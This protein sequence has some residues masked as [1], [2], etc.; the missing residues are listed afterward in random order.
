MSRAI[1]DQVCTALKSRQTWEERQIVWRQMRRDGLRRRRKPY[2]GAA[3]LHFPLISMQ[4]EKL[5][6]FYYGQ[7]FAND[8]L[9]RFGGLIPQ[10]RAAESAAAEFFDWQIKN[11]S[12]FNLEL[13]FLIDAMLISGRGVLKVRWGMDRIVFECVDPLF[14][15]VPDY[16]TDLEEAPWVCQV[17][18]MSK[19]QYEAEPLYEQNPDLIKAIAGKDDTAQGD[20]EQYQ[21]AGITEADDAGQIILWEVWTRCE[22]KWLVSTFSPKAPDKPVR[23][24]FYAARLQFVDFPFELCERG[25]YG[26]MGVAEHQAPFEAWCCK[27]WN[28][29]A[30]A[31]DFFNKPL[32][33]TTGQIRNTQNL[34]FAPGEMLPDG[35]EAVQMP[36][37]PISFDNEMMQTHRLAQEAISMP[38]ANM[39]SMNQGRDNPTAREVAYRQQLSGQ[40]VTMRG[41]IFRASLARLYRLAWALLVENQAGAIAQFSA[42]SQQNLPAEALI[43]NFL[44]EPDGAVDTWNRE[45][46][47][48]RSAQR[49]QMFAGHPNVIQAELVKSVLE[50][51]DARLVK[52]L[53]RDDQ[54][55]QA[56]E[57]EDEAMEIVL[58]MS[59]YPAAVMPGENHQLRISILTSKLQ[60]LS[61]M[62][63]PVDPLAKQRLQEHIAQHI[64]ALQQ[65]NPALARQI[66]AAAMELDA[67]AEAPPMP[68]QEQPQPELMQEQPV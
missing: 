14:V 57:S 12:N 26:A 20:R 62:G 65:E 34:R 29:K 35:I 25:W 49:M 2:P 60:Q 38:D 1:K 37:P 22:G 58:L 11:A 30:D 48:A 23:M 21:R 68:G 33:T 53:F 64:Q 36:A 18:Q 43:E 46:R 8:L 16:V 59:G 10:L 28:A 40:G 5:K 24:P 45:A 4:I 54:Q 50:D 39:G 27:Q 6:P 63:V 32:F 55:K 61:M 56:M 44:I 66:E 13:F 41:M 42:M 47:K 67:P 15:V 19:A 9:A 7:A 52:R 3:D 31:M 17:K 51:D